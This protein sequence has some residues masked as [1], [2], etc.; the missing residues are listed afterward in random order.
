ML[1][2]EKLI[3]AHTAVTDS[4]SHVKRLKSNRYFVWQE[5]GENTL[6]AGNMHTE[7]AVSGSTDLYTK[8]EFDPWVDQLSASFDANGISYSYAFIDYEE[9][10]GF[11]HHEWQWEVV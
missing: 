10:T 8:Q 6:T 5:D 11:Y 2:Y 7:S 9:D 4:V 3:S 1:W